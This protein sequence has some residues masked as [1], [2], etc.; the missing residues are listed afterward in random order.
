MHSLT[1]MPTTIRVIPAPFLSIFAI[2]GSKQISLANS[3][4]IL[5]FSI[6]AVDDK[7]DNSGAVTLQPSL[8]MIHHLHGRSAPLEFLDCCHA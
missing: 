8:A 6:P 5:L 2:A 3:N 4:L 1:H 7:S